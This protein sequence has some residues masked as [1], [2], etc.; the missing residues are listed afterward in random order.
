M[1]CHEQRNGKRCGREAT[2]YIVNRMGN[3]HPV[4]SGHF[5]AYLTWGGYE[6]GPIGNLLHQT[7]VKVKACD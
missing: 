2:A 4:C 5:K 6:F 3:E 7:P 1:K